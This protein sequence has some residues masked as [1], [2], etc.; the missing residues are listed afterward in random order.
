MAWLW[1]PAILMN[2]LL[3]LI[4]ILLARVVEQP[5]PTPQVCSLSACQ[6][7]RCI[8]SDFGSMS[9]KIKLV[10]TYWAL[11]LQSGLW[12]IYVMSKEN[13]K[14]DTKLLDFTELVRQSSEIESI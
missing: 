12:T 14:M 3:C 4:E 2:N 13:S 8:E 11:A 6:T 9:S 1:P 5:T 10:V 7:Q